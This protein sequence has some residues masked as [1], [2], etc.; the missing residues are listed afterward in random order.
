MAVCHIHF[1]GVNMDRKVIPVIIAAKMSTP[2][3]IR[4]IFIGRKLVCESPS[5]N[6]T[7]QARNPGTSPKLTPRAD[8]LVTATSLDVAISGWKSV[9]GATR[10]C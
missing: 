5:T 7:W 2:P 10:R 4:N 1:N 9:P 3:E 6:P 8:C